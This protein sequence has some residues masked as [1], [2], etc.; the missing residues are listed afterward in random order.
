MRLSPL[1]SSALSAGVVSSIAA[2]MLF[3]AAALAHHGKD[4]LLASTAHLPKAG[5]AFVISRQDYIDKEQGSEGG[6]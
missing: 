3:P 6:A 4:F 1:L 5:D 2:Q